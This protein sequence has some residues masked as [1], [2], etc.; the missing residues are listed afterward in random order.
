MKDLFSCSV[1]ICYR[2]GLVL[3]SLALILLASCAHQLPAPSSSKPFNWKSDRFAFANETVW[4]YET[5]PPEEKKSEPEEQEAYSRRCFVMSRAALQFR[6]FAR[7]E[8]GAA[9][10]SEAELSKRIRQVAAKPVWESELPAN[11]RIVFPGIAGL[12]DFSKQHSALL[13]KDIGAGWPTYFRPGNMAM[14]FPVSRDHQQRTADELQQM[15]RD[16]QPAVL[17]LT[18]FP[19]LA[20]NHSVLAYAVRSKGAL[21]EFDVYDPNYTDSPKQLTYDPAEK[22]FSYQKT[23]YFKGG[24]VIARTVYWSPLQ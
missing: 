20:I 16:G 5:P 1:P 19:S 12:F 18:R 4:T 9:K 14:P 24:P 8:P 23:F 13:Q 6:K 21:L 7:F 17:W 11:E 10:V 2:P 22:T 3:L 15:I